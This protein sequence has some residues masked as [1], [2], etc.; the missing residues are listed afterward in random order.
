M[1]GHRALYADGWKVVTRHQPGTPFDDDVWELYHVEVDRSESHDL[2]AERP[3]KVDELVALWWEEAEAKGVLPL[4]DR[5]I[6]LFGAR[7]RDRSPHPTS[8]HY[9]YRP[10]MSP[11][12]AQVAPALG[13]R[14]WDLR[15]TVDRAAGAGG[16]LYA[17]GTETSGL[18]LFLDG[19]DLVFD[20][21]CFG[22]HHVARSSRPVP[23][24]PSVVGVDLRRSGRSG[25][26]TVVIDG[27]P[28]GSVEIPFVM[29]M[30]SSIGPSLGYDHGSP[31]SDQYEGPN[32]F[33]G[34]IE[35]IDVQLVKPA[36]PRAESAEAEVDERSTM[37]R[38]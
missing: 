20:Y 31:V 23:A 36:T 17:S 35:R 19:D 15:A 13:G 8:R 3:E 2:A 30:I 18:S 25:T 29:H 4:D 21:N 6:E 38:Q 33:A 22:D 34:T 12:P 24:G 28:C 1:M 16:V 27:E 9:T 7:F 32:P 14:S 10:P 5:T 11:L 37:A 26:A